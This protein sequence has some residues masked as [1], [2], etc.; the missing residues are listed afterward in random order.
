MKSNNSASLPKIY[1][2]CVDVK[3]SSR[4]SFKSLSTK[5][6]H[7]VKGFCQEFG[8]TSFSESSVKSIIE[9]F[10]FLEIPKDKIEMISFDWIGYIDEESVDSEIFSDED[11]TQS[12][13][14]SSPKEYGIWYRSGHAYYW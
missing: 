3:F 9:D 6:N 11:I 5:K 8:V 4:L 12:P 2:V 7:R 13:T 10:I 14:F 1:Y